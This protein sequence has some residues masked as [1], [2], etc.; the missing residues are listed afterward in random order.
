MSSADRIASLEALVAGL[1][2]QVARLTAEVERLK[3]FEARVAALEAENAALREKLAKSSR[4]S[5]K[6]PSSDGPK[7][8]AER[9]TKKPTGRAAGGQPGHPKHERPAW[10]AEKVSKRIVLRPDQ[11]AE[12]TSPLVGE[13]PKPH[14]HQLFDLP[15]VE[16][17]VTEFL[18]HS[19]GCKRCGHVT[20]APLPV[21]VPSRIFGPSVDAVI[22]YLMGVHKLGK[23]GAAEALF[24]LYG[25]PISVG[26]IVDSQREVSDALAEPYHEIV[27]HAQAAPVKNAD[28]TSWVEGK[29][30]KARA[31]LWT[32]VTTHAI[33]FMIQKTRATDGA[34]KLLL[35]GKTRIGELVFGVLGTD[36]H[37]AYN[38]WPLRCRQFCWSHLIRDFTAIS[39][40]PGSSGRIGSKLIEETNRMF[41]WW[42]RV[43]DGTLS[44]SSFRVYMRSL[45]MRVEALLAEGSE[46]DDLKTSRTCA[47]LVKT[48]V[49]LWTFVRI[50]GVEPTNNSAER[51]VRHGVLVRKVSGGTKSDGGSRFIERILT[52]RATLRLQH[53]PILQFIQDACQAR[54]RGT[55]PPSLLPIEVSKMLESRSKLRIAA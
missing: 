33:V 39:E 17:I 35:N 51:A 24:D 23:R 8:K 34:I 3:P 20:R 36:R 49:A 6:P 45:A 16:P 10:P 28:E 32:L 26:A 15:K 42:H 48:K 37:G 43:R 13:D 14:R 4:N 11:C 27:A 5:S 18:Q 25:L 22:G 44:R 52:A 12:C 47:K 50:E 29:G 55:S 41:G 7:E 46:L 53:R 21:G 54:L 9:R 31:W 40:R 19:L 1:L 30:K 2:E 38:F